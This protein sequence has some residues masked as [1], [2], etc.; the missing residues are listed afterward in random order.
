MK[1]LNL[2]QGAHFIANSKKK[3]ITFD[4]GNQKYSTKKSDSAITFIQQKNVRILPSN[5]RPFGNDQEVETLLLEAQ[6]R[7]NASLVGKIWDEIVTHT[8]D[9]LESNTKMY[10]VFACILLALIII[11]YCAC[12]G[13]CSCQG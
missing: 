12:T 13:R 9:H 10:A 8:S 5:L 1:I 6:K 11:I 7:N 3:T 4:C 2:I